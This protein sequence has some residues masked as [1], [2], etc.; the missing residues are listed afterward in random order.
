MRA[1]IQI[2]ELDV[3]NDSAKVSSIDDRRIRGNDALNPRP[4]ELQSGCLRLPGATDNDSTNLLS[5]NN[6]TNLIYSCILE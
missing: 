5:D 3:E 1:Q 4:E 2:G 6:S